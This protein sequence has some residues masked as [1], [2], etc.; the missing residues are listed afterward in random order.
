[1]WLWQSGGV[2]DL[3]PLMTLVISNTCG[4]SSSPAPDEQSGAFL[5]LCRL[6]HQRQIVFALLVVTSMTSTV[7]FKTLTPGILT[8]G[9]VLLHVV[10]QVATSPASPTMISRTS[11]IC[12]DNTSRSLEPPLS[13]FTIV[14]LFLPA[15]PHSL[16][17]T[18]GSQLHRQ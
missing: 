14:S 10:P 4:S 1:M 17:L 2:A 3:L 13:R 7:I 16:T 8:T 18:L 11:M 6:S 9:V 5:S 12:P 15:S